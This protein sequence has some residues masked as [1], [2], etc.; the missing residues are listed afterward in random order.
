MEGHRLQASNGKQDGN[1]YY[2]TKLPF[3]LQKFDAKAQQLKWTS[4]LSNVYN[5]NPS[6]RK[7]FAQ[8]NSRR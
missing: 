1:L 5:G 8:K 4:L 3:L 2:S 7:N 6:M